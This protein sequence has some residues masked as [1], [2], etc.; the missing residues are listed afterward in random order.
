MET[1]HFENSGTVYVISTPK[2]PMP[3]K[4]QLFSAGYD[5]EVSQRLSGASYLTENYK[6]YPVFAA[7][8]QFFIKTQGQVYHLCCGEGQSYRCEHHCTK[9][10]CG[11]NSSSLQVKSPFLP[12]WVRTVKCGSLKSKAAQNSRRPL[13]YMLAL[14]LQTLNIKA[15]RVNTRTAAFISVRSH[16]TSNMR[17]TKS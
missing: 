10:F 3:W 14:N 7:E 4:N 11:K 12:P 5:M 17:N 1:G 16:I 6:R 8:K 2:T 13:N 15:C 9:Q